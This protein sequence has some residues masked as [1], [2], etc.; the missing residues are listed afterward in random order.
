MAKKSIL[1]S[2]T[3]EEL[4]GNVDIANEESR[5]ESEQMSL[6]TIMS[7][8]NF[9]L[10]FQSMDDLFDG[11]YDMLEDYIPLERAIKII[12]EINTYV[13][14]SE[15]MQQQFLERYGKTSN[16]YRDLMWVRDGVGAMRPMPSNIWELKNFSYDIFEVV[17]NLAS[18][19]NSNLIKNKTIVRMAMLRFYILGLAD[20]L[21]NKLGFG[22]I[23][24]VETMQRFFLMITA[25]KELE[26]CYALNDD[27]MLEKLLKISSRANAERRHG[28]KSVRAIELAL[29]AWNFGCELLH[30]QMRLLLVYAEIVDNDK[31]N[32]VSG[33]L[34][35]V[36]PANRIFGP[37]QKKIIDTCPCHKEKDCPLVKDLNLTKRFD[38]P[39]SG[40]SSKV[41]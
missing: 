19:V 24:F 41:K 17:I 6:A 31:S 28:N 4:F 1:D 9:S 7:N 35:K 27:D 26:L 13:E 11:I 14:V 2:R 36:A 23:G 16:K 15:E 37:G 25:V 29:M 38:L 18:N 20:D 8:D 34:K 32:I 5:F 3:V 21:V 33:R 22:N 30:T 10:C 39:V 12:K 40:K